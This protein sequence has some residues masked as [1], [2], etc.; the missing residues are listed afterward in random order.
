MAFLALSR[1]GMLKEQFKYIHVVR[2]EHSSKAVKGS[3]MAFKAQAIQLEFNTQVVW[4]R[5]QRQPNML[6][7]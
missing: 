1:F 4:T 6:S 3:A 5:C 2:R 7:T